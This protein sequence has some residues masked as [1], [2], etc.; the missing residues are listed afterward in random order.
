MRDIYMGTV[1]ASNLSRYHAQ[2]HLILADSAQ[3]AGDKILA[4]GEETFP[5][6]AFDFRISVKPLTDEELRDI[7]N[8]C[9]E[10]GELVVGH[11]PLDDE[12]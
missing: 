6:G 2:S 12:H 8:I 5:D 1:T 10:R 7:I 9:R 11:S 3:E 4:Y